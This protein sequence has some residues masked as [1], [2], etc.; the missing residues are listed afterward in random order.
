MNNEAV[1]HFGLVSFVWGETLLHFGQG[2]DFL[3]FIDKMA[4]LHM[5]GIVICFVILQ[6]KFKLSHTAS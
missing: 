6:T 4:K 1:V 3:I 2:R 5:K